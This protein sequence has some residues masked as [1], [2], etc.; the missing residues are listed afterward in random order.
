MSDPKKEPRVENKRS[1]ELKNSSSHLLPFPLVGKYTPARNPARAYSEDSRRSPKELKKQKRSGPSKRYVIECPYLS[2]KE[3]ERVPQTLKQIRAFNEGPYL[4]LVGALLSAF[5]SLWQAENLSKTVREETKKGFRVLFRWLVRSYFLSGPSYTNKRVKEL[6]AWARYYTSWCSETEPPGVSQGNIG[7][8]GTR[9]LFPWCKGLLVHWRRVPMEFGEGEPPH[10]TLVELS[11]FAA[12][13]RS[14]PPGDERVCNKA[15]QSHEEILTSYLPTTRERPEMANA[16]RILARSFV[17]TNRPKELPQHLS[18]ASTGCYEFGQSGGGRSHYISLLFLNTFLTEKIKKEEIERCLE[19]DWEEV[20]TLEGFSQRRRP[21]EEALKSGEEEF[22]LSSLLLKDSYDPDPLNGTIRIPPSMRG[23]DTEELISRLEEMF[24]IRVKERPQ[25]L[26]ALFCVREG[27][28][29]E[30]ISYPEGELFLINGVPFYKKKEPRV[31]GQGRRSLLTRIAA[32]PEKGWK[33]RVVTVSEGWHTILLHLSRSAL[34]SILGRDPRSTLFLKGKELYYLTRALQTPVRDD[35]RKEGKR[36]RILRELK[37]KKLFGL[38]SDLTAATDETHRCYID[39]VLQGTEEAFQRDIG[40]HAAYLPISFISTKVN[41]GKHDSRWSFEED[42]KQQEESREV[43]RGYLMGNPANWY[44]LNVFNL[45][46]LTLAKLQGS[47]S[48]PRF[49]KWLRT[50]NA[51]RRL[52][53]SI[54]AFQNEMFTKVCGDDLIT[55]QDLRTCHNYGALMNLCGNRLSEGAH[56]ISPHTFLFTEDIALRKGVKLDPLDVVFLKSLTP[57]DDPKGDLHG[58][59][60]PPFFT[61]GPALAKAMVYLPEPGEEDFY[62][63]KARKKVL[64]S[65]L[66]QVYRDRIEPLRGLGIPPFIPQSMGGLGLPYYKGRKKSTRLLHPLWKKKIQWLMSNQEPMELLHAEGKVTL[67]KKSKKGN[68]IGEFIRKECEKVPTYTDESL[69]VLFRE[70]LPHESHPG[71]YYTD[72]KTG[73]VEIS[74]RSFRK[75]RDQKFQTIPMLMGKVQ[76][77]LRRGVFPMEKQQQKREER[78][79]YSFSELKKRLQENWK[80]VA[81]GKTME[82]REDFD[83]TFS[84]FRGFPTLYFDKE[85]CKG[86]LKLLEL[87]EPEIIPEI[88]MP[89]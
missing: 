70:E 16:L 20:F 3:A 51:E 56:L 87:G 25:E 10:Q 85:F 72:R 55:I 78:S 89:D 47:W 12:G 63:G 28:Q 8:V 64:S 31:L 48:L 34:Y 59:T 69:R 50:P 24:K 43:T 30:R 18:L 88:P 41:Y 54:R 32:L 77:T 81:S 46:I 5:P 79:H 76:K 53:R 74:F 19:G 36:Q 66:Y 40:P 15:L 21:L 75:W 49:L 26:L 22:L 82:V 27:V 61:R 14:L 71:D 39:K 42:E 38:S 1:K 60:P 80:E 44:L 33:T 86:L 73:K 29:R 58:A 11:H 57:G 84:D 6:F 23:E 83:K 62:D 65:L 7:R 13:K 37:E 52:E 2:Q 35:A 68:P 67:T 45:S 9:L 4:A 17:K